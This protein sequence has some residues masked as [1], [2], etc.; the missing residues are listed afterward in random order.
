MKKSILIL[1]FVSILLVFNTSCSK[2]E[3]QL[4]VELLEG[5]GSYSQQDDTSTIRL[6]AS[7]NLEQSNIVREDMLAAITAW[8]FTI[9]EAG[10]ITLIINNE[11]YPLI[12]GDIFINFS[13]GLHLGSL[14]V[15]IELPSSLA[16]DIFNGG[17]PDNM[18]MLMF[19]VDENGSGYEVTG[20]ADFEFTR[21]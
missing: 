11:N 18:E 16:G 15:I 2:A 1:I 8:Q 4:A 13:S 9:K 12:L 10:Q 3:I 7:V 21:N 14:Y 17:N 19:A 5:S 6:V 20:A